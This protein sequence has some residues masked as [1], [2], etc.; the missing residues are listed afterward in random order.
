MASKSIITQIATMA[1]TEGFFTMLWEQQY[2]RRENN[3]TYKQLYDRLRI[4]TTNAILNLKKESGGLSPKETRRV[5]ERLMELKNR[6]FKDKPLDAMD[7]IS[8]SLDLLNTILNRVPKT[9][10]KYQLTQDVW[11]K[12]RAMEHYFDRSKKYEDPAGL[13][14]AETFRELIGG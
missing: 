10:T 7:A 4:S 11:Y 6:S 13:V 3:K 9:S 5:N 2:Q 14:A 1:L 12:V 8:M